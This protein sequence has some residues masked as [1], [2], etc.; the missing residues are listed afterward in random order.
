VGLINI[1]ENNW[2]SKSSAVNA[3]K[4]YLNLTAVASIKLCLGWI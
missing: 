1:L 3:L 4:K 2:V